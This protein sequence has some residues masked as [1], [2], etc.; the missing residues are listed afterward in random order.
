MKETGIKLAPIGMAP[1]FRYGKD[2]PWGGVGLRFYV[3]PAPT[4]ARVLVARP[5]DPRL[6]LSDTSLSPA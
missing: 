1:A 2:T 5:A 3:R 6:V 4:C